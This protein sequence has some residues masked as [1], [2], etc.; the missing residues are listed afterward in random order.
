MTERLVY[1]GPYNN[2]RTN[3]L[4]N[5]G[6]DYLEQNIGNRFYYIL[7]NGNLLER[8][9][10]KMIKTVKGTFDINLFTFDDIVDRLL[11][12]NLYTYIDGEMKEA[13]ISKILRELNENNKL[14]YYKNIS[15]KKGF[16]KSLVRIIGEIKDL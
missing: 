6:I 2:S 7:P 10:E 16:V 5:K 3:D 13:L 4:F 1:L 12:N 14:K 8:Y 11:E 15:N 9:R